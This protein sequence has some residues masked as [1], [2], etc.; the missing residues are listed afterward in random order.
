MTKPL[1][2]VITRNCPDSVVHYL[3]EA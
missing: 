3:D 1:V 2:V